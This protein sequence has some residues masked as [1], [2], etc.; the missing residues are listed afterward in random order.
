V[1]AATEVAARPQDV[2]PAPPAPV[3]PATPPAPAPMPSAAVDPKERLAKW[4]AV[5]PP[6]YLALT[7]RS[8]RDADA[9]A[10]DAAMVHYSAGRYRQAA[11]GLHP[12]AARTPDAAHV[13]FFLGISQLMTG[14]LAEARGALQRS[15]DTG[16]TPYSDEAHFYLAKAALRAGDLDAARRELTIAVDREA[17]PLGQ[18][19][20]MLAD[21]TLKSER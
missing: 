21:I 20:R 2:S 12:L 13:Q 4:A 9:E 14:K 5:T 8:E 16:V 10:F 3:A 6:Q 11:D 1:T 17:G 7:T 18:A 15:A 19:A